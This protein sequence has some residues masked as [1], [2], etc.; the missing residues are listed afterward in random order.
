M[1]A[2]LQITFL[3][4][5]GLVAQSAIA[6]SLVRNGNINSNLNT[7]TKLKLK[8]STTL[9]DIQTQLSYSRVAN[10]QLKSTALNGITTQSSQKPI[11][12]VAITGA[13]IAGLSLAHAL[14]STN[15]MNDD[16]NATPI[17]IDIFDSRQDLDEKSGSGECTHLMF[18]VAYC[19]SLW[20]SNLL[21]FNYTRVTIQQ[22]YS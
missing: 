16:I 17:Q 18:F 12:R 3:F 11:E 7:D 5:L 4:I 15:L 9:N 22:G 1:T 20:I 8:S 10:T 14:R 6:F 13:G 21:S 2:C 19:M